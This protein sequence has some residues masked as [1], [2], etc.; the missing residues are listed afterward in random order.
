MK[1]SAILVIYLRL[2]C[3]CILNYL[4]GWYHLFDII[5]PNTPIAKE[6]RAHLLATFK[7]A[8]D[9]WTFQN[10]PIKKSGEV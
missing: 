10:N 4:K 3:Q 2:A 5:Q 9:N 6:A 1:Q 7:Y 8:V